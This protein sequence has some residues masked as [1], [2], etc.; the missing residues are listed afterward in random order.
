M[1]TATGITRTC[2]LTDSSELERLTRVVR[3]HYTCYIPARVIRC[4]FTRPPYNGHHTEV[5]SGDQSG[6]S[7]YT[8]RFTRRGKVH[9][10][11]AGVCPHR[12]VLV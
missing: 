6:V 12:A 9:N 7:I 10:M 2:E 11:A 4:T 5:Y 8:R 3:R 1:N